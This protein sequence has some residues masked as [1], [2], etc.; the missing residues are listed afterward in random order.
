MALKTSDVVA[1][2]AM[3]DIICR[4]RN[5]S[6]ER[7]ADRTRF[8]HW[9]ADLPVRPERGVEV[10]HRAAAV[11]TRCGTRTSC[12]Q[13]G[14]SVLPSNL[15]TRSPTSVKVFSGK[16]YCTTCCTSFTYGSSSP[17]VFSV[18][19]ARANDGWNEKFR[20]AFMIDALVRP[21]GD[22]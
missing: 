22:A 2:R 8:A 11:A 5:A 18:M 7:S 3:G 13:L 21:S 19:P 15:V 10:P 12:C 14:F 1:A 16:W 20:A 9:A 4:Y 6:I 17:L